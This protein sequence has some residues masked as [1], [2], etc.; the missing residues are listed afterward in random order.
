MTERKEILD[1]I[2]DEL[3][4]GLNS[5]KHPFH[6]FSV[7]T[8]KN[9]KPD[10]RTVV[11]RAVD[12]ENKSISFHTDLRSKKVLQIK[13]SE[14]ICALFYD[15]DT[16]IQLRIYGSASKET[17]SLLIKEKWNSSKEMSKLCYLNKISPSEVI[18][19]SKDYLYG[20]EELNNVE[21]GI[22]NFSIINIK[23]SQIDWLSLNHE[24]HQRMLINYTSNNKIEFDWVAP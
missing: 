8:V 21:L 16:K 6:I 10:S 4:L 19:E 20:K 24:G 11:L 18:N 2:W 12:K 17:D 23:I 7:S 5:G 15:K 9:N 13:E 3:T 14:N 1:K 22:K